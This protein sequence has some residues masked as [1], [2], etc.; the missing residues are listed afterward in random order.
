MI[1]PLSLLGY[2][3]WED[4]SGIPQILILPMASSAPKSAGKRVVKWHK[5]FYK[6]ISLASKEK[7]HPTGLSRVPVLGEG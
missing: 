3:H 5:S 7:L 6:A 2:L 1:I 4:D